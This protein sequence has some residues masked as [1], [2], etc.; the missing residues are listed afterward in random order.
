M[1]KNKNLLPRNLDQ[2]A[3]NSS[4][5]YTSSD[6][7][8]STNRP[9]QGQLIVSSQKYATVSGNLGLDC[10]GGVRQVNLSA[11]GGVRM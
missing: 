4:M 11:T 2:L 6:L 1:N 8:S 3:V 10:L 5:M 9:G 7:A